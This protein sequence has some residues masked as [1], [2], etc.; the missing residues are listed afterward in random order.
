MLPTPSPHPRRRDVASLL[1]NIYQEH[2]PRLRHR[3]LLTDD[4]IVLRQPRQTFDEQYIASLAENIKLVGLLKSLIV[5]G[6][7]AVKFRQYLRAKNRVWGTRYRLRQFRPSRDGRS[8]V[9]HVLI[10]GECRLRAI[11]R[12]GWP[13]VDARFGHDVDPISAMYIQ[14]A[15]NSYVPPPEHE[16]A[17]AYQRLFSVIRQ[18]DPEFPVAAFARH[19]RRSPETIRRALQFCALP[20]AVQEGVQRGA[21]RYGI[22]VEL[23]RLQ[24]FVEDGELLDLMRGAVINETK[25]PDFRVLVGKRLDALRSGQ[26][27]LL[28]AIMA[29][30][31][32][33]ESKRLYRRRTVNRQYNQALDAARR[34]VQLV[35]D[36]VRSGQL[37]TNLS[38]YADGSV[39][40]RLRRLVDLLEGELPHLRKVM[41]AVDAARLERLAPKL[42]AALDRLDAIVPESELAPHG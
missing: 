31:Q 19:V 35:S 39:R 11:R 10:A 8:P 29:A 22:A 2:P 37:G 24:S 17:Y 15:E 32:E 6:Y 20:F 1:G 33:A 4:I 21:I 38:P 5:V 34:Y 30:A 12:L 18:A 40:R 42:R 14:N 23:A 27:D 9:Y 26:Q 16:Q 13:R 3:R 25:V 28:R 7:S 41:R 36:L